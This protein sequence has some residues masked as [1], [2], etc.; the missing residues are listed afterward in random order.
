MSNDVECTRF[1]TYTYL[2]GACKI[3][4]SGFYCNSS[5][6]HAYRPMNTS[7]MIRVRDQNVFTCSIIPYLYPLIHDLGIIW[8][9]CVTSPIV[10]RGAHDMGRAAI[11]DVENSILKGKHACTVN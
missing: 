4:D 9:R 11:D 6:A 3:V 1:Y 5:Q 8:K 10:W 2:V 7:V